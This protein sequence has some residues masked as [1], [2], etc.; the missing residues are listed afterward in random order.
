MHVWGSMVEYLEYLSDAL[1]LAL[2]R[3]SWDRARSLPLYLG[4][5]ADD[6]LC[7]CD[8]TD[9]LVA[10]PR[11]GQSLPE[12]KRV[13]AQIA[14]FTEL[15]VALASDLIDSRQRRA[16]VARG[17]PVIISPE[18]LPAGLSAPLSVLATAVEGRG[19][20]PATRA[21]QTPTVLQALRGMTLAWAAACGRA[22]EIGSLEWGKKADIVFLSASPLS[23][24]PDRIR[25]LRVRTTVLDGKTVY[26]EPTAADA[27]TPLPLAL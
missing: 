22:E 15:P 6:E 27:P 26:K 3:T 4:T 7:S 10:L 25:R 5:A 12:L 21:A 16:L 23:L 18:G 13:V 1:G 20:S 2:R 8:G 11:G 9:F 24:S 17:I 14:R 19:F